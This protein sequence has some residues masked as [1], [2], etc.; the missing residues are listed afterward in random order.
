[1][2]LQ[3]LRIPYKI[4]G[5]AVFLSLI[6][7]TYV[8]ILSLK[9]SDLEDRYSDLLDNNA[10]AS[11][12]LARSM[13]RLEQMGY[14]AYRVMVYD[15]GSKEETAASDAFSDAQTKHDD[16][17]KTASTLL[18]GRVK[19]IGALARQGDQIKKLAAEA[20]AAGR[21]N[22]N[23]KA[24]QLLSR[25]DPMFDKAFD[26]TAVVL[27]AINDHTR[28]GSKEMTAE[29]TFMSRLIL[30][31][32]VVTGLLGLGVALLI[33]SKSIT[34]PLA[35]LQESMRSLAGGDLQTDVAGQSRGDEI[36]QM[37][38]AVQV[39]KDEGL[40]ARQLETEALNAR[41]D[42]DDQR[43]RTEAERAANAREQAQV[44]RNLG[45]GLSKLS[46]GD[47]TIRLRDFPADYRKLEEDFNVAIEKLESAMTII[48]G[49]G[50][51]IASGSTEIVQAADNL[52]Q[53][54]EQQAAS[55]EETAA[56]LD[57]ITATVRATAEGS[58]HAHEVVRAAK[59]G[60]EQSGE[61]V[62]KAVS[63]MGA[64][65]KSATEISQIITVID[66]IAFQTN[67]LALNA[68]VEAARA[69]EAGRGFA[70]VASEVRALAQRSADAA[71]EIKAL[72][73]TSGQQVGTGVNLVGETGKA[74]N[75]IVEQVSEI[76][77]IVSEIAA[78]AQEQAS[79]LQ[80]VNSAVNQMD[81]ITQQNAAMVEQST[82]ASH[83]LKKEAEELNASIDRFTL[84]DRA[85]NVTPISSR[86]ISKP[87]HRPVAARPAPARQSGSAAAARQL[88]APANDWAEF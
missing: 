78:S 14:S 24:K 83:S 60:A 27:K 56:A 11:I 82:A 81:Q 43:G 51:S 35:K 23:D 31:L 39:F 77:G 53:R 76:A 41:T 50:R 49:N 26:D 13:T 12:S 4:A 66:E 47:L 33:S 85:G 69:G 64:I 25:L 86:P 87:L 73:S 61:V 2:K 54:T 32:S 74:L 20:M 15:A 29:I 5:I 28:D 7:I 36:G 80:Q 1:M 58:K 17:I 48:A 59:T 67:L 71:K 22:E 46:N 65:A 6:T 37:A 45:E 3:D 16:N 18:P 70:V 52:S 21:R 34:G 63:A 62:R 42:A 9:L 72:I 38:R 57:Q 68:G 44:V 10:Q 75:L 55:L 84:R 19:E 79:G 8:V 88:E 40:R 30:L